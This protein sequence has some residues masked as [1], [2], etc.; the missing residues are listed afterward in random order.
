MLLEKELAL[1]DARS[2]ANEFNDTLQEMYFALFPSLPVERLLYCPD[3]EKAFC[4]A[5]RARC[6]RKL[7]DEMILRRLLNLRKRFG[8]F[9]GG[10]KRKARA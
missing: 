2:D 9:G 8:G 4:K 3:D 6:G 5:I 10:A 1:Y 7:P